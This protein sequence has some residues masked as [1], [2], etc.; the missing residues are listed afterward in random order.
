[1]WNFDWLIEI[2]IIGIINFIRKIKI[3]RIKCIQSLKS[4]IRRNWS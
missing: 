2:E 3:R 1:M 4:I